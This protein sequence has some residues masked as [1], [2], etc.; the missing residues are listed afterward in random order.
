MKTVVAHKAHADFGSMLVTVYFSMASTFQDT[1]LYLQVFTGR[2]VSVYFG[3]HKIAIANHVAWHVA[4][5]APTVNFKAQSE[6]HHYSCE[7]G[8]NS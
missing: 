6:H 2:K 1:V 7:D 4:A 8:S 5:F 3:V